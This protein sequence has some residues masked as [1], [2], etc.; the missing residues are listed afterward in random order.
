MSQL[1]HGTVPCANVKEGGHGSVNCVTLANYKCSKCYLVH[2]CYHPTFIELRRKQSDLV[3][4]NDLSTVG[5]NV[6]PRT[7]LSTSSIAI[8][9]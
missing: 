6:R 8:P 3:A 1:V 7:G 9:L 2:V 4:D 5:L